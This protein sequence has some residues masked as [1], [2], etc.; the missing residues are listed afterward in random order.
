MSTD[1]LRL[2]ADRAAQQYA[3]IVESSEDAILSKDLGRKAGHD[4]QAIAKM[5][6]HDPRAHPPR[7][8]IELYENGSAAE[9]RKSRLHIPDSV[10]DRDPAGN[11]HWRIQDAP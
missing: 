5:K 6:S 2:S 7:E 11:V 10:A 1:R 9:G 3:A 8:R 4:S